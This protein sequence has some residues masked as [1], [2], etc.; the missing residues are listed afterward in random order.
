M[1]SGVRII[2]AD[3]GLANLAVVSLVLEPG[4]L[5]VVDSWEHVRTKP[6]PKK[7]QIYAHDDLSRRVIDVHR[8]LHE[9]WCG[10]DVRPTIA[11]CSESVQSVRSARSSMQIGLGWG[12]LISLALD[13]GLPF[14]QVMPQQLKEQ[15]CGKGNASKVEVAASLCGRISAPDEFPLDNDHVVDAAAAAITAVETSP[16]IQAALLAGRK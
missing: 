15:L 4:S 9:W 1:G 3:P 14:L 2:G 6:A 12:V 16:M 10:L 11:M 13:H 7:R 8:A 5:P